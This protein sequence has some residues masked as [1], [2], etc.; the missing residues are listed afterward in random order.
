MVEL[1][2]IRVSYINNVMGLL[3]A[4]VEENGMKKEEK[5]YRRFA[6]SL[7]GKILNTNNYD[8]RALTFSHNMYACILK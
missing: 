8:F 1:G 2:E 5:L 7:N 4:T 3:S 6:K